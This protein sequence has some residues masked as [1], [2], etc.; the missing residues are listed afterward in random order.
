[1]TDRKLMQQALAA[2]ENFAR[3]QR[4]MMDGP[5]VSDKLLAEDYA[6]A[7]FLQGAKTITALRT[8]LAQPPQQEKLMPITDDHGQALR[9]QYQVIE[10]RGQW[11][12]L[13]D[14]Y[15]V[16][17]TVRHEFR[18]QKLQH[19]IAL[20]PGITLAEAQKRFREKVESDSRGTHD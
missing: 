5:D 14:Q 2:L 19:D 17:E 3:F 8:A 10:Q 12:L 20:Y 16:G 6:E 7:G 11:Q 9:P 4:M 1:M 15:Q 18:I 13:Y